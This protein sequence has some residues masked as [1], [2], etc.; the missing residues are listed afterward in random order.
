MSSRINVDLSFFID[1]RFKALAKDLGC[2]ILAQGSMLNAWAIAMDFYKN[3]RSL[4]PETVF[5][6]IPNSDLILKS[7]LA[8]KR[9]NGFYIKGSEKR[10]GWY[11]DKAKA[12]KKGGLAKAS[13]SL[14]VLRS[15]SPVLST[16]SPVLSKSYLHPPPLTLPLNK[17]H[18]PVVEEFVNLKKEI[19]NGFKTALSV[20]RQINNPDKIRL[21]S[22]IEKNIDRI[23]EHFTDYTEF[24]RFVNQALNEKRR[25]PEN[26]LIAATLRE[27]GAM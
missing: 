7:E 19:E 26:Y 18:P 27:I 4:I 5:K 3:D 17:L 1:P 10:F 23:A 6:F 15:A 12:G 11:F 22:T 25:N 16:A 9:E 14:A 24:K 2:E 8:E 21:P 13:R 20:I